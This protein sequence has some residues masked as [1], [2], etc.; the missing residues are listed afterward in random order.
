MRARNMN[1]FPLLIFSLLLTM[2]FGVGCNKGE[3]ANVVAKAPDL[4]PLPPPEPV[5]EVQKEKPVYVYSGDRFRDPFIPAGQATNYQ[6]DAVFDPARAAVK[7][8]IF[9]KDHRSAVL[10]VGGSGTYFIKGGK[11]FDVMGKTVEGYS[12]KI[13]VDKVVLAGEADNVF[14]LKIKATE[15]EGKTL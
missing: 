5:A 4:P 2:L 15:E 6:P 3:E 1:G 9:G 8:I 10:T 14:E 13:F 7:G 12:V 11:I